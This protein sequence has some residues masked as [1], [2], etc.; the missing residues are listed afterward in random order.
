MAHGATPY[1]SAYACTA[2]AMITSCGWVDSL[3]YTFT[4]RK[5]LKDTMPGGGSSRRGRGSDWDNDLGSKGIT[6]TR[7]VTVEGG[8]VMD[9]LSPKDGGYSRPPSYP[10]HSH[11]ISNATWERPS[12][13]TGS[14]DPILS[15][16]VT[17]GL[18]TKKEMEVGTKEITDDEQAKQDE[19]TAF[20]RSWPR[21]HE[22]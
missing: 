13:P 12:S 22:R 7:T 17:P 1:S 15:G 20:P 5:L 4:R 19:I 11:N 10:S 9:T 18:G 14:I 2:G 6:H 16:R 3:L 21:H 8:Q